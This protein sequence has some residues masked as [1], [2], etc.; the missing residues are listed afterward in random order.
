MKRL[1]YTLTFCYFFGNLVSSQTLPG[2]TLLSPPDQSSHTTAPSLQWSQV[3]GNAGYYVQ[4]NNAS[5]NEMCGSLVGANTT[6]WV[7]SCFNSLTAGINYYWRVR[8]R[9]ADGT[10]GPWS[11]QYWAFKRTATTINMSVSGTPVS[12]GNVNVGQSSTKQVIFTNQSSSTANLTITPGFLNPPFS[13]DGIASYII[14]PGNSK[15]INITFSPTSAGSFG[16]T[17]TVTHN[18][19]NQ[20]SPLNITVG[21]TGTQTTVINMTVNPTSVDFGNV[22]VG[23]TVTR[24]VTFTN[25]SSSNSNLGITANFL[26]APFSHDALASYIIT[27]GNSRTINVSFSP[28]SAGSFSQNWR[29]DHNATNQS[30]P[31]YIPLSGTGTQTT[32]IN[33]TVNPTS[34]DFGNVPVGQTVTRA[35]TFTNQSSSNSNLGITANFLN[36]PF[37]HDALASYI[38]TPGNSRTINVSFSPTSVGSFSQNWRIDHNATNQSSPAYIPLSGTGVER[39]INMS[40]VANKNTFT[41]YENINFTITLKDQFNNPVSNHVI[42]VFDPNPDLLF[43]PA[44]FTNS[45]GV[46][47]YSTNTDTLEGWISYGFYTDTVKTIY[48]ILVTNQS[49]NDPDINI[50]SNVNPVGFTPQVGQA[51]Q[52]ITADD[53]QDVL[54]TASVNTLT[55]PVIVGGGLLCLGGVVG[56]FFTAGATSPVAAVVCAATIDAAYGNFM[57]EAGKGAAIKLVEHSN[58]NPTDKENIKKGVEVVAWG[59]D[60]ISLRNGVIESPQGGNSVLTYRISNN[61]G[62]FANRYATNFLSQMGSFAD[63]VQSTDDLN[64]ILVSKS[65]IN[66]SIEAVNIVC[67]IKDPNSASVKKVFFSDTVFFDRYYLTSIGFTYNK[68]KITVVESSPVNIPQQYHLYQNFPNPFN[69]STTINYALPFR[70]SVYLKIFNLLGQEVKTLVENIQDAGYKSIEFFPANLPSGLYFYRLVA[71]NLNDPSIVYTDTKT[72]LLVK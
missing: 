66:D 26:N 44:I 37:S 10:L 20:S 27:P 33:M 17:W 65:V 1:F 16:Q 8:T 4:V 55:D 2:P 38:I 19:T 67:R 32:V 47:T 58:M 15:T 22:P 61:Q 51:S 40:V 64:N 35:V 49:F 36:A 72:M 13:H 60:M 30:S 56:S 42:A 28:T 34:V 52:P 23:Q 3:S 11:N 69:P 18:A 14:T 5:G 46:A 63:M 12:F 59:T 71:V 54:L 43:C 39:I 29:I 70:S 21:G 62:N 41:F 57:M 50:V 24:A 7:V 25:Q 9:G 6:S 68:N 53:V 48:S 31:T 45:S